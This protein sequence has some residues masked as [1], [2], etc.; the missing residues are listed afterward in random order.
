MRI[1]VISNLYPPYCLGGYEI[2]CRDIVE[3]LKSRGHDVRVL[4]STF[5]VDR[6]ERSG[7][8]HRWLENDL[9][10]KIDGSPA[11]L[12]KII[13]KELINRQ[14]FGR[15]CK[16][17]M[18]DVVY[19]WNLTH[20]SISIAFI[21]QQ[22][23]LRVCYFISDHWLSSWESDALYSLKNRSPRKLLRRLAWR[24]VI[25]L[26]NA[27]G[28]LPRTA[29]DLTRVQFA[30]R[31]LKQAALQ[32]GRLVANAEVIPWGIDGNRFPFRKASPGQKRLLY[33]GQVTLHKGVHIAVEA[34]K[35][36]VRQ[37]GHRSTILTIVGGPDYDNR[38]H[39]LV[40]SLNLEGNVVFTG[41]VSRDQL[42]AIYREHD[43]LLFPS[44]WDEPFSIALLEAM[45]S[46][47]AVVGT[48]TGGTAE[49]LEDEVNALIFPKEDSEAC[50]EQ[51]AR[52]IEA[53]QLFERIRHNGR[54]KVED[55]FRLEHMVDRID[56]ALKNAG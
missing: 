46:G 43:L 19:L 47:L 16:E 45:S 21:A 4:T 42:P 8:V 41:R 7:Y 3:A 36:L 32:A 20:I 30:S 23:G 5:G 25:S 51:M 53:P 31:F 18:P 44:V 9:G 13:K 12:L 52:L 24:P 28:F 17:F 49:I 39:R 54:R 14:A 56:L 37:P 33:V 15:I 38:I 40:S 34:L 27:S 1:L 22:M 35:R 48:N 10:L 6:F 29:L 26:I 2:G 11:D 50:A 55:G